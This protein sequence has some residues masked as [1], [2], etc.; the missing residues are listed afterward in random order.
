SGPGGRRL[1]RRYG[2]P[3]V[4]QLPLLREAAAPRSL[5]SAA[6]TASMKESYRRTASQ[7]NPEPASISRHGSADVINLSALLASCCRPIQRS[8]GHPTRLPTCDATATSRSVEPSVARVFAMLA[9]CS[10][11][12]GRDIAESEQRMVVSPNG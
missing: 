5:P 1:E 9:H 10:L 6:L 11:R 4:A 7:R 12:P 8:T 3:N 2:M